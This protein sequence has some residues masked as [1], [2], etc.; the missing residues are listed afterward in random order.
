VFRDASEAGQKGLESY[1]PKSLPEAAPQ[2]LEGTENTCPLSSVS[3]GW[4]AIGKR[5]NSSLRPR[6][7]SFSVSIHFGG[8][9]LSK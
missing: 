3:Y 5:R 6:G 4:S 7:F 2:R 8:P 9:Y 1:P